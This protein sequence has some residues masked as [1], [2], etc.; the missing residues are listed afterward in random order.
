M[1]PKRSSHIS[2]RIQKVNANNRISRNHSRSSNNIQ[3][4]AAHTKD[5]H[6]VPDFYMGIIIDDRTCSKSGTAKR[7]QFETGIIRY[8][9]YPILGYN[10]A[11]AE[12]CHT[13][14]IDSLF[15]P[16]VLCCWP[17]NAGTL[18]IQ[19]ITHGLRV[20]PLL[21]LA[22]VLNNAPAFMAQDM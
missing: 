1:A 13:T 7:R 19:R 14:R 5:N 16:R 2:L 4:Y 21:C 6:P 22:L 10:R 17:L 8:S 9:R 3:T 15:A 11:G 12:G 20:S 18:F